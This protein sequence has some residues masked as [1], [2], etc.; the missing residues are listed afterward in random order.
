MSELYCSKF[1]MVWTQMLKQ[2]IILFLPFLSPLTQPFSLL[3]PFSLS[4]PLSLS[5]SLSLS[6][7]TYL[8]PQSSRQALISPWFLLRLK[9]L[10][11]MV[12][13]FSWI[14]FSGGD[15]WVGVGFWLLGCIYQL[16]WW[17]RWVLQSFA[18]L[19]FAGFCGSLVF[20]WVGVYFGDFGWLIFYSFFFFLKQYWVVVGCTCGWWQRIVLVYGGVDFIN[21]YF[22]FFLN[23]VEVLFI[24]V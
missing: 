17:R 19:W 8:R 20:Q 14:L 21:Y 6:Q 22:F 10:I 9:P 11:A 16:Y 4:Q 24:V 1:G 15:R 13:P 7:V 2:N 18:G 12:T 3:F 5:L 23:S